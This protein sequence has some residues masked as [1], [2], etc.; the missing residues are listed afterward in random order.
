[1]APPLA[2]LSSSSTKSRTS[3]FNF[4]TAAS[5]EAISAASTISSS[6]AFASDSCRKLSTALFN[7]ATAASNDAM[8]S[9]MDSLAT[10]LSIGLPTRSRSRT[11]VLTTLITGVSVES[12]VLS[13]ATENSIIY[14]LNYEQKQ[15]RINS[16]EFSKNATNFIISFSELSLHIPKWQGG[17]DLFLFIHNP[18]D[19]NIASFF[20]TSKCIRIRMNESNARS[21]AQFY[22]SFK[23]K[24]DFFFVAVLVLF[25]GEH[26][27]L[28]LNPKI[29]RRIKIES[30]DSVVDVHL[31]FD[32]RLF[33]DGHS[34]FIR[35][36]S[37]PYSR[38]VRCTI[39]FF[40]S[41]YRLLVNA[42]Q[43]W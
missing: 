41:R 4:S 42:C 27:A 12:V 16:G 33:T 18:H 9:L 32:F 24:A 30:F 5:S 17:T 2:A 8:S 6:L 15:K 43:Y 11:F 22:L 34:N 14:W 23:Q 20:P 37:R 19:T 3:P 39:Q 40:L 13:T 7:S 26:K 35:F 38:C 25:V 1:M 36:F 28:A 10:A 31:P 29:N 21:T